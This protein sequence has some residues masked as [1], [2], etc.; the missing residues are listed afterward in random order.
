MS[1]CVV[2]ISPLLYYTHSLT[3]V[4][5]TVYDPIPKWMSLQ[6]DRAPA[7]LLRF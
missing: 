6:V 2:N 5:A 1:I 7:A 3:E 4:I